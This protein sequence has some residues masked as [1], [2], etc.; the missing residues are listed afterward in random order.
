MTY[1]ILAI[2]AAYLTVTSLLALW[3][4]RSLEFALTLITGNVVD[5]PYALSWAVQFILSP[6]MLMFNLVSEVVRLAV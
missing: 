1:L 6:V 3:T 5:V 4:D 2:V